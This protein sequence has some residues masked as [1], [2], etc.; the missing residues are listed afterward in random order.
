M[1]NIVVQKMLLMISGVF[2]TQ[3]FGFEALTIERIEYGAVC[4]IC[5]IN[6]DAEYW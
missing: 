1:C 3:N 6:G 2:V 5:I 4:I